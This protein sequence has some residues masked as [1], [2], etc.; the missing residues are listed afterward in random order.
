MNRLAM[1][2]LAG[3][4]MSGAIKAARAFDALPADTTLIFAALVLVQCFYTVV[5]N[6]FE[7]PKASVW[8]I[9][10]FALFIPAAMWAPP[11]ELGDARVLELF[12]TALLAALA[13]TI[14]IQERRQVAELAFWVALLGSVASID[15]LLTVPRATDLGHVRIS[16][17]GAND[18]LSLGRSASAALVVLAVAGLIREMPRT[19][20]AVLAAPLV[21]VLIR[22]ASQGPSLGL[23]L[24]ALMAGFA[25][26]RTRRHR[27]ATGLTVAAVWTAGIAAALQTATEAQRERLVTMGTSEQVRLT[28]W[29]DSLGL[30][31]ANP[32]GVGWGGFSWALDLPNLTYPH[33]AWLEV[34]V[35]GGWLP[36]L[37]FFVLTV[38]ALGRL[39][40]AATADRTMIYPMALAIWAVVNAAVT[41]SFPANRPLLGLL[42]IAAVIPRLSHRDIASRRPDSAEPVAG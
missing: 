3:L 34:L 27:L 36:G 21:T 6:G 20:A 37:S 2:P 41:G 8:V 38:L 18:P 33:N 23:V 26:S 11:T 9:A 19:L 42:A 31:A 14:L 5:R 25:V 1:L 24:G 32:Q 13:P 16:L 29:G 17:G 7:V 15:G 28:M 30:A 40:N 10:L 22:T 35:E 4:L 12:T 39:I